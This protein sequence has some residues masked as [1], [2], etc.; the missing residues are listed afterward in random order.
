MGQKK[1]PPHG[2]GQGWEKKKIPTRKV[3]YIST[4]AR[5]W[6]VPPSGEQVQWASMDTATWL[7]WPVAQWRTRPPD[8]CLALSGPAKPLQLTFGSIGSCGTL[9]RYPKR[10]P[11]APR[12]ALI[13]LRT[14]SGENYTSSQR[15]SADNFFSL[16]TLSSK[17]HHN[18]I[19]RHFLDP[20]SS[21]VFCESVRI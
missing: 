12:S 2:A 19:P 11:T 8:R 5:E 14:P 16:S 9:N 1:K 6:G 4:G 20:V 21:R 18:E 15:P 17:E 10:G 7:E 3:A 13:G